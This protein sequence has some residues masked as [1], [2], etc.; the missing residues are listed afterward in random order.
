MVALLT[1]ASSC[2]RSQFSSTTRQYKNGRAIYVNNYHKE[3]SKTSKGKSPKSQLKVIDAQNSEAAP[4]R[5]RVQNLAGL[6]ITEINPV[7]I[8]DNENLIASTSNVPT[9]LAMN[10]N[11]ELVNANLIPDT[12]KSN[13][14]NKGAIIDNSIEQVIKF[15]SGNVESVKII[16]Q[17][18]DML[19]FKSILEPEIERGIK[20]DRIDTIYQI[21]HYDPIKGK[22]VDTRKNEPRSVVGFISSL[23]GLVPIVGIPFAILAMIL[24]HHG[25]KRIRANPVRYKG[26]KF[27]KASKIIG[28]TGLI[29]S[30]IAIIAAASGILKGCIN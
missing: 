24:G 30:G 13:V 15:K 19:Y 18:N 16:S 28:I 1:V 20:I 14:P 29:L 17:S 10:E 3:R 26:T 25:L 21:Q 22:V 23:L 7:P 9:I 5:T 12:I 11:R 4:A 27:A 2:Q 6:K 8:Q